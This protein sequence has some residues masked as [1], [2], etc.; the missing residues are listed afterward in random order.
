MKLIL[1]VAAIVAAFTALIYFLIVIASR[2][3]A[4]FI[5]GVI[6]I[7]LFDIHVWLKLFLTFNYGF[8]LLVIKAML[9]KDKIDDD[10]MTNEYYNMEVEEYESLG[11]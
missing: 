2:T 3:F 10:C 6:L 4:L 1:I 8:V 11:V 9:S 5:L 7:W